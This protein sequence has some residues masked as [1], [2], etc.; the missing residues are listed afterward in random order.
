MTG[1]GRPVGLA[2]VDLGATS[3][4]VMLGIVDAGGIELLAAHRFPNRLTKHEG[5]LCW[6]IDELWA[7][8][9]LGL[10]AA[11]RLARERGLAGLSAIGVDSWAVDYALMGPEGDRI[12]EVV[13]YRDDRTDGEADAFAKLL[14]PARQFELTGIAQQ[15]FNTLYQLRAD[16][17]V[18]ELPAEAS[19]LLVPDLIGFLLTGERRTE[20]TNASTTGMLAQDGTGWSPE[21]LAATGLD[22][23]LFP[24][25]IQPGERLGTVRPELAE[26]LDLGQVPVLAVGSHD[27]ASAVLAIPAGEGGAAVADAPRQDADIRSTVAYISSGTWS[28][29]GLELPAAVATEEAR[30]AGFTNE[31][32]V[33]GTVRFL[34]NVA[35]MWLVSE[36]IRQW[37]EDGEDVTLEGLLAAAAEEPADRLRI[38][39]T[40]EEFLAPGR[41][42]D[43]IARAAQPLGEEPSPTSPVQ[44]VRLILESLA[45]TYRNELQQACKLAGVPLPERLHVVGGGSR[46][47]LLNQLTADALGIEVVA[48]PMEATALGN[49]ALQAGSVGVVPEEPGALRA[50]VHRSVQLEHFT[51]SRRT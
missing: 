50:L 26:E 3:G 31:A 15:P 37:E 19:L 49:V 4:R 39:P 28:L 41:M 45:E 6:E 12:G 43:R 17:R 14:P 32:G 48:G 22:P 7:Q 44:L 8:I 27:T 46:N 18:Q 21:I 1:Q 9:R 30:Q 35:G 16:E 5:R 38:D 10:A 33:D 29:I 23:A 11:A 47:A 2:A 51:P 24:P 34:K 25:L 40:S 36:S 13:S 42:A 20:V